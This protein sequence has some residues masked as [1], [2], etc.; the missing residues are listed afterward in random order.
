M[1]FTKLCLLTA[2][3]LT[4]FAAVGPAPASDN[5]DGLAP[6]EDTTPGTIVLDGTIRDF[7][8]SHPDFETFP[9]TYNKV[10][11][12]L[13]P[14]GLPLLD[15]SYYNSKKGTSE[16]S[17]ESPASFAQWYQTIDGVNLEI[18]YQITLNQDPDRPGLYV[19]AREKQLPAPY[20]YFFPIDDRGFGLTPDTA[21][22]PL[23]WAAGGVHNFHFTYELS[24][25][26]T[27][28]DP[29]T[30]D[31]DG[32]GVAGEAF[33]SEDNPG[34]AL[35][36]SF[37][38]DDDVWVFVNGQLVV[39]LGGVH[40]Q[41]SASVN[42]DDI[43]EDLG[44]TVGRTYELKLFFAERHTSESNFRIETTLQLSTETS[45]LYD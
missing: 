33:S 35:H 26:F 38:G 14:D 10:E 32:D 30:R 27:Y 1:R 2:L 11:S 3:G 41:Q 22:W 23:R 15:M 37:T 8:T 13:G 24:T 40:S 45:P 17:V 7:Q 19:F 4:P 12:Q 43:A 16:Q 42:I 25:L 9:G 20:N 18:P 6:A 39:D 31:L 29:A 5:L 21:E 36:F 44:L 28:S 34:D